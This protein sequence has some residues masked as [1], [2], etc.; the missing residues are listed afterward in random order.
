MQVPGGN[1][2]GINPLAEEFLIN[3]YIKDGSHVRLWVRAIDVMGNTAI[4]FADVHIDNTQPR[5]AN[6]K[7]VKNVANGTF[8]YTS[9]YNTS[10]FIICSINT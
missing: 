10:T 1:W 7:I 8:L 2:T 6:E 3:D 4:D 9:R 5:A